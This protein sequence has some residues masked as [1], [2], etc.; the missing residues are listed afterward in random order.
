MGG[1]N[2]TLSRG[3]ERGYDHAVEALH[4]L[5][6]RYLGE[7]QLSKKGAGIGAVSCIDFEVERT[8]RTK[9]TKRISTNGAI[10][11]QRIIVRY[12][13]GQMRFVVEHLRGHIDLFALTDIRRIAHDGV[14]ERRRE[15]VNSII[16]RCG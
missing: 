5:A 15:V 8:A 13:K 4:I 3:L 14:V 11:E 6:K 12:K 1:L 16:N 7:A 2:H 10:E 9:V